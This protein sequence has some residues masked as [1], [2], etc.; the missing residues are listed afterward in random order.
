MIF[1][2]LAS[3]SKGNATIIKVGSRTILIDIGISYKILEDRL[4]KIGVN[5]NDIDTL[6]ITHSHSDHTKGLLTFL[7][8]VNP[9]LYMSEETYEELNL[10]IP[11]NKI[12]P[13]FKIDDININ[14]IR[15]SH[16]VAC[17]GY[18]ISYNESSLVYITDTG[19]INEKYLDI[20]SNK[21]VYIFESNH[22]IEMNLK[23]RKP[24][25][26]RMR[27]VSDIGH[28]SNKQAGYYLAKIV[29]NDTKDVFLAHLSEEDNKPELALEE[30]EN[31][32]KKVNKKV[33]LYTANQHIATELVEV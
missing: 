9:D 13:S 33:N 28:L 8:K 18:I 32:L 24:V 1:S 14:T 29:G 2:V 22:D 15:L 4:L 10:D 21:N 7:K 12:T 31:Q 3:G 19:Y 11:Y 5:V 30:V 20:L 26:Y 17:F 6:L 27:V 25:K 16:D 23:S